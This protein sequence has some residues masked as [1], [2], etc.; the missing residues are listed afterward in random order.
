MIFLVFK[1]IK[2]PAK[3][4]LSIKKPAKAGLTSNNSQ[5][6]L[7]RAHIGFPQ[8]RQGFVFQTEL[9]RNHANHI[10]L[11]NSHYTRLRRHRLTLIRQAQRLDLAN[12]TARAQIML[13]RE[14]GSRGLIKRA[15]LGKLNNHRISICTH[16]NLL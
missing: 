10:G 13:F 2:K 9:G 7:Q 15:S 11:P 1:S 3:A 8:A 12:Y 4:G 14:G 5:Q 6:L 16:V